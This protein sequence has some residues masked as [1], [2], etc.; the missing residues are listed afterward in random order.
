MVQRSR[1]G[2]QTILG[3]VGVETACAHGLYPWRQNA[4]GRQR[5]PSS[6]LSPVFVVDK[7]H[8]LHFKTSAFSPVTG[9]KVVRTLIDRPQIGHGISSSLL[10]IT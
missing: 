1:R 9:P 6:S 2:G 3:L 7:P 4:T 8:G 5:V 10:F